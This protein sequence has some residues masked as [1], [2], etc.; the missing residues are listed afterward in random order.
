[1]AVERSIPAPRLGVCYYPEQWPESRWAGDAARMAEI[2]LKQVRVGEFA[3]SRIE[4]SPDA[5]DWA[6][7]DRAIET[8]A[9]EGLGVV[10]GTP[11]A[12]PPKWLI[13]RHPD[14]LAYDKQGRPRRFGSRRHYCFSSERYRA[15]AARIV[16]ALAERYGQHGAV[17]AWQTDNEYGC[18]DTV[19]SYSPEAERAFRGWLAA[20]YSDVAALNT[21]W[22]TV[23][24]SQEYRSFGEIDLPNLTV[25][26]PNPSHVLD[27]FR[28]SS[29]Q[30]VSFN[31]L[32]TDILRKMSPGK[33]ILHNFMGLFFDFDHFALAADL[34]IAAWD[35]YPL[36]FLDVAPFPDEDKIRYRRQGHPDIAGFH[37][38]LY[39]AAGRGRFQVIEQQPGPVNWAP[40]NPAPLPGMARLWALE[41]AAHGAE[42]VSYFRWRQAPFA[43]EQMHA[44]LLRPDDKP[45]PAYEEA[46]QAARDFGALGAARAA[47][48]PVA[49]IFSYDAHW[50]FEAQPQGAAW[51]YSGLVFE[52]YSALRRFGLDVDIIPPQADFSA[53]KAI[54]TPSLPILDDAFVSS[55][56]K[57]DA[58]TLFGPRTGSKTLSLTIPE[59]LAPGALKALIPLTVT[60]V[61]SLPADH[62]EPGHFNGADIAG[63]L[64]LEHVETALEPLAARADGAG[65]LYRG[66]HAFYL[67]T[68]PDH[69]FLAA[70]FAAILT[71][72]GVAI[73]PVPPDIRLRR[74]GDLTFAFNYGPEPHDISA[75]AGG[76]E[77]ML[78]GRRLEPA[79]V[80][81]WRS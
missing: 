74:R 37:H 72:A 4:P 8:L 20:R 22:G 63:R 53:Y 77:F 2:G 34:D 17:I 51:S 68:V 62:R 47:K 59:G 46:R 36:G 38:D 40:H 26:E 1:M 57:S 80:A 67:T 71:E 52:W 73:S 49:L 14:I 43:Q 76:A 29:D 61:E 58:F 18:H 28:F 50:L 35:S 75:I 41:G 15:E 21:A 5:F 3:W 13:D 33:P 54:F 70:L 65:L 16:E 48:A 55:I 39:R 6:W 32:Q 42:A 7:L 31:R 24:W 60:Y 27:F 44:G 56:G 25:T 12:T 69:A 66:D 78:G 11:T 30:V 81:V 19:R 64:W 9:H 23:F 10:L 45:A 79:G